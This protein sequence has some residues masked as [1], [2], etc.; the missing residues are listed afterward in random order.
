[1]IAY[2]RPVDEAECRMSF[3]QHALDD[4]TAAPCGRCDVCAGPWYSTDVPEAAAQAASAVLDRPGVELPPRAQWPTG[5]DRLGVD[6]KGK[7]AA[8]DALEPGRAVARLTD[9]GWGQRLRTLLGDDGVG[10]TVVLDLEAPGIE[11]DPDAAFDVPVRR[12]VTDVPPDD[13][14]LAACARVLARGTGRTVPLRSWRCRHVVVRS[15]SPAWRRASPG[16]GR[17]PYLGEM[18]LQHGGPTGQ[19]GGNSAFR[20]AAVWDRIVVGQE[21]R[22]QL[23]SVSAP[24]LLVDDLADSRWTMTVAGRELR[25][26][27]AASVLPF[28]LALTA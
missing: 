2:A 8:T 12:S 18:S 25:R 4:P 26:A 21:L 3:L 13:A 7:I 5:A 28:A 16:S 14:L 11:E 22:Q 1:M 23:A 6:V 27:G 24:V 10:G 19:P 17:L 9:L 20:L 15:W